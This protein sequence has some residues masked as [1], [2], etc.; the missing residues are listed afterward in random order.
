M[1]DTTCGACRYVYGPEE[2]STTRLCRR[3]PP[4]AMSESGHSAFPAVAADDWCG[5]YQAA[6]GAK[7]VNV[8]V[9]HASQAGATLECTMGNW[10]G[11]PAAYAY[12]WLLDGGPGI[13]GTGPTYAVTPDDV[14]RHA[15]CIVTASNA[16]GS[17]EA[18]PSNDV[19]IEA[20]PAGRGTRRG[21]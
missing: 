2:G 14:G 1:S 11:E 10:S 8:D 17:T 21:S 15:A 12:Q 16:A 4:V 7:P 3:Y 9:P 18:P 5:E 13:V 20:P 19:L 6:P